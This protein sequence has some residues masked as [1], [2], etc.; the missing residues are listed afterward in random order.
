MVNFILKSA[1]N[2]RIFRFFCQELNSTNKDLLY[3][4]AVRWLSKGI[5]IAHVFELMD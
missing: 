4:T 1:L 5:V 3:Y 2:T